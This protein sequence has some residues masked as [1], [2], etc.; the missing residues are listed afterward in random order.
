VRA[1]NSVLSVNCD[2]HGQPEGNNS[3]P[4]SNGIP[5]AFTSSSEL[6][7]QL[8]HSGKNQPPSDGTKM[9]SLGPGQ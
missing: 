6:A 3:E 1:L 9:G 4:T 2:H 5:V 8:R 7:R